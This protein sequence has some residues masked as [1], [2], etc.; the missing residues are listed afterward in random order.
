[1][2]SDEKVS[3]KN[4]IKTPTV[5]QMEAAECGAASLCMILSYY[6]LWVPLEK[7]RQECG[8]NRDGASAKNIVIAARNRGCTANGYKWPAEMLKDAEFPLLIHWE[9]N[10]FVVLEGIKKNKVYINDPAVGHRVVPFDDF[11]TS[12]TGIALQIKP[13]E[14]FVK[15]GRPYSIVKVVGQKLWENKVSTLFMLLVCA[16]LIIPGL[17]T[18]VFGQIFLDDILTGKH[19]DWMFSLTIAIVGTFILESILI[20]LRS[21]CLTRWQTKLVLSDSSKFFWHLLQLPIEFFQQRFSAEVA[22]RVSFNESVAG[23]LTGSAA[24]AVLDFFVA[25][26]Y[27]ILLF[28]YNVSLTIVGIFFSLINVFMFLFIRKKLLE[29]SMKVQQDSGKEYGT[30]MNGLTMI[31][32]LKANGTEDEFF[33]KWAGYRTKVLAGSQKM[34]LYNTTVQ[35]LPVLLSGINTAL[36]MSIGGFSIM[37]GLMT[38][39]I[40]MAFQSLMGNFQ[41]PFNSLL[42]LANTLQTT[43]MQMKRL[44]DVL[45]YKKDT[46]NYPEKQPES[47][48]K[49][50]LS[51]DVELRDIVFGYS[52]LHTPLFDNFQLKL[53]SGEWVALVGSS[54][55]G[56]STIAKIIMGLYKEWRGEVLFDGIERSKIPREVI[57][58]S[59]ASVDQDIFLLSGTIEENIT[60]F[61]NSIRHQDVIRAAQDACIHD[62]ILNLEDGYEAQ[63]G[64]G[65]FNFSGGQRQRLEIARAL[66]INPS[67]LVLDEATSALDPLTEK[68]IIQNIRRR[69]CSC[70]V[71]AHRLST[72]RDCDKIIVIDHG[73]IKECGNHRQLI[74]AG[75]IYQH[76]ITEQTNEENDKGGVIS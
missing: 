6:G 52:N 16:C 14:S 40:F 28:Q 27:L 20:W 58:N 62:D 43:E 23:V 45:Q 18:P 9:F 44:D 26:F 21:W 49:A 37:D 55:C 48:G 32:S 63:V 60:L 47:I 64:E 31:E 22:S 15:E 39:G 34:F 2:H 7:L 12:Y 11:I 3:K 24:T 8:V 29:M 38:A 53:K 50:R 41:S 70:I 57:C 25:L 76:L 42:G 30:A 19:K 13:K 74:N 73:Q 72:I 35:M 56:K 51:G 33:S 4:R 36:I 71:V 17:A 69:G 1:M 10:H 65:G 5:L 59:L 68:Q 46:L 67:I 66:A 54:G 75:G 61:D